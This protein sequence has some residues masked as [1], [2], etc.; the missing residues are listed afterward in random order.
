MR[1]LAPPERPLPDMARRALGMDDEF[2][3]QM[4][5]ALGGCA[6]GDVARL[7]RIA[8]YLQAQYVGRAA[9]ADA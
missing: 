7:S 3:A 8:R 1:R 9:E 4:S 6:L 5:G 2:A